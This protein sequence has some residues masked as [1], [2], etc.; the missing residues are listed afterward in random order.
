MPIIWKT[1][2]PKNQ[3]NCAN[4]NVCRAEFWK[5]WTQCTKMLP[6]LMSVV[7]YAWTLHTGKIQSATIIV[8][9]RRKEWMKCMQ[10]TVNIW[11]RTMKMKKKIYRTR[12]PDNLWSTWLDRIHH[13]TAAASNVDENDWE[14]R[15]NLF[16]CFLCRASNESRIFVV[17]AL[18]SVFVVVMRHSQCH[19]CVFVQ[20][21]G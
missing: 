4:S 1:T 5:P 10:Q 9:Y 17:G 7:N 13:T 16:L 21:F 2:V 18:K 14:L 12:E 6:A 11:S 15:S 20:L 3:T 19:S 8:A